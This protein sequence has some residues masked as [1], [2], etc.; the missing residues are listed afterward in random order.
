MTLGICL[1]ASLLVMGTVAAGLAAAAPSSFSALAASVVPGLL[2]ASPNIS[3]PADLTP[4]LATA[5]DDVP[6]AAAEPCHSRYGE[7]YPGSCKFLKHGNKLVL[8]IGDSLAVQWF[9]AIYR[10]AKEHRWRF[11]TMT[12]SAC[13]VAD[14]PTDRQGKPDTA[15]ET[16]RKNAFAKVKRLHP[17]L[18]IASSLD[19]YTFV[20]DGGHPTSPRSQSIWGAGLQRSLVSLRKASGKVVMLGDVQ[21]WGRGAIPCLEAHPNNIGR[22]EVPADLPL[23]VRREKTARKAAAAARVSFASTRKLTCPSDPCPLVV[24]RYLVTRD[25]G[26]LSATFAATLWRGM[27]QLLPSP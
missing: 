11:I 6:R 5:K 9:P 15:C 3:L 2:A 16:W 22:C 14:V 27:D 1:V 21:H 20:G 7:T 13:P 12:K 8:L 4:T 17:D 26:H 10:V 24:G 25:G 19:V 18:V 23:Q